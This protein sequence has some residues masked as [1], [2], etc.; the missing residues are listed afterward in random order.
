MSLLKNIT[1]NVTIFFYFEP[2]HPTFPVKISG[3]DTVAR[4]KLSGYGMRS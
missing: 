4:F 2:L 3:Y 1:N